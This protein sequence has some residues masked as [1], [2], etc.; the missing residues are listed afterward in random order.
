MFY[1][2][3]QISPFLIMRFAIPHGLSFLRANM[4]SLTKSV[5]LIFR[6][7]QALSVLHFMRHVLLS[8]RL[9]G[10]HYLMARNCQYG[11]AP[12]QMLCSI[13]PFVEGTV[14]AYIFNPYSWLLSLVTMRF[15]Y[16]SHFL[17]FLESVALAVTNNDSS[18]PQQHAEPTDRA[19]TALAT[20]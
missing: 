8:A 6:K 19:P 15:S 5:S 1:E 20:M 13:S 18:V 9:C 16:Y 4:R 11:V 3:A 17:C 14:L 12:H 2:V 10:Y 7:R